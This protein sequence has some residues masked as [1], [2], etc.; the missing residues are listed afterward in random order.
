VYHLVPNTTYSF[1]VWATNQLGRGEIVEVEGHTHHS[2]EELGILLQLLLHNY[3]II[4]TIVNRN[5]NSKN[6]SF[7]LG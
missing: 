7:I 6:L 5:Y 1:R 2:T 3:F 4:M